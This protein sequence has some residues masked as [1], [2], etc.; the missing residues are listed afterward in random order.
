MHLLRLLVLLL[1]PLLSLQAA[2]QAPVPPAAADVGARLDALAERKLAEAE[3]RS[4]Q[5]ALEQALEQLAAAADYRQQLAALK[6]KLGSALP[7]TAD[8]RRQLATLQAGNGHL[9]EF[10]ADT[11]PAQLEERLAERNT[12]LA[13]WQRRLDEANTLLVDS[14]TGPERAQTE[15]SANQARMAAIEAALKS[16][17]EPDRD[18]RP[19]GS[20]RR[21]ALAA[22]WHA[23]EAQTALRR[24]ELAGNSLLQDLG[25]ARHD[26]ASLQVQRLGQ[27][28]QVLQ[29]AINARRS[30]N[31]V[32]AVE[33]LEAAAG[34]GRHAG[35]G[36][37]LAREA[38]A[39]QQLSDYLLRT[40]E[41]LN[42]LTQRN[43]ATRQQLDSLNRNR[44]LIDEQIEVLQ[45]SLLL[46]RILLEQKRAL[47]Q[48]AV[49]AQL[50]EQIADI[51]LYQF[52]INKQR[53]QL[54]QPAAY[55]ERLLAQ[56]PAEEADG[57]LREQLGALLA[58]RAELLERL[59]RE[60][61]ALLN[62]S[63]TL[64]LNE[65]QLQTTTD[66]LRTTLDE[67]MFWIPSNRPLDFGW[68]QALPGAL[69]AQLGAIPWQS[70][71]TELWTGL[72]ARPFLFLPV[73][74]LTLILLWRRRWLRARLDGVHADIGYVRRDSQL[75]TPL[76]IL[77]NVLLALPVSLLLAL[78]GLALQM[79]ARGQNASLGA[80]L[81]QMAE[82]W[83]VFY[84]AYRVLEPGGVAERHFHVAGAL[85][86]ELYLHMRHLG[87]VV[88]AVVAIVTIAERQ[89][90]GLADDVLGL[91]TLLAGYASMA[92]LMGRLLVHKSSATR[93]SPLRAALAV[94]LALMPL[95]L[96]GALLTGYYY[97]ALKL[98]G[99]LIDTLFVLIA[100]RLLEAMLRRALEV[101]ARRLVYQRAVE[102]REA[103]EREGRTGAD[104]DD[105]ADIPSLDVDKINQQS[106]RLLRL[107]LLGGL[108]GALYWVWA[109]LIT[110]FA[111]LDNIV[112]Y[113]FTAA[114][115][116]SGTPISLRDVL[117]ALLIA[118][119]AFILAANLPGLLEV[120]VLSRMKLAQGSAYAATT[121]LSY[122]IAGVGIVATFATLG[123]SWDKLQW[124]VAAL[125]VGL[126]FGLQE[127][128]ANFVSGLIILFERPVRIGDVVTIGNV[129]GTVSRIQIRATTIT[130]FD[131]KEIIVPN[132][133][134]ITGQ[135]INWSLTDTVTRVT[136]KVGVAYGADLELTRR[137]LLQIAK[138]N[139]R[140]LEEPAP[141]A[142]FLA[143]GA[144]TLDHELRIH[145]REL[146]DRNAAIDE[147]N[148]AID[149][150]FREHGIEIAFNQMDVH[151][152]SVADGREAKLQTVMPPPAGEGSGQ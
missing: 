77:F 54:A 82:A 78:A 3:H 94:A 12:A 135:L 146:A 88:L 7:R 111:Y 123:V 116:S 131:R 95:A 144:S 140:V 104:G 17:R 89:P 44:S 86:R 42:T 16:G 90:E 76:A 56:A 97:T 68:L 141:L 22:E 125:S 101:A 34:E 118:G 75:H 98:T 39:N 72:Q 15:I 114:D 47:P 87:L 62:E 57:A 46:S 139:P 96:I 71:S 19:L 80:A 67:Q 52:E 100:W 99:R 93:P 83:L 31:A 92:W 106:L 14:R 8:A 4:A 60:L 115:G 41:H 1:L 122:V 79:D 63:I 91:L 33:T 124:L 36:G 2:A 53:E 27:Q 103:A 9:P 150:L 129:S 6:E 59:N 28:I 18:S 55:A 29:A 58:A 69:H 109:D 145:V 32:E 38:A 73:L 107:G 21:D 102:R 35:A 48:P 20:E 74:L 25:Q 30:A 43:L 66:N 119:I 13:G 128:F 65:R 10:A 37:L 70:A 64:Q 133:A 152:R 149:R 49:D 113:Q 26:L 137:L 50:T 134:F 81:V 130:D 136:V 84:T 148:R 121:L 120:L 138:D 147:I 5:Q 85:T 112:L 51:R 45:G 110:V 117:G 132:K 11:S 23:L 143:F 151:I 40:T 142:L 127:I 61:S 105:I 24:E 108:L 126:G